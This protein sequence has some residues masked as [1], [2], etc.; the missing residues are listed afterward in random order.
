LRH[1]Y[2]A[3]RALVRAKISLL[4]ATAADDDDAHAYLEQCA[5]HLGHAVVHLLV[6]GGL[7]GTGK[8]TLAAAVSERTGWHLV[9]S[10][11][12]RKHLVGLD[13]SDHRPASFGQGIYR[14][15]VS[16]EVY[17]QMIRTAEHLLQRGESVILDASF[18]S[19]AA[20]RS[21]RSVAARTWSSITSFAVS[22]PGHWWRPGST[23]RMRRAVSRHR[24]QSPVRDPGTGVSS[25]TSQVGGC[26]G[27]AARVPRSMV[28][29]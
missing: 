18:A 3:Y 17:A 22:L 14:A 12:V 16:A 8:S 26:H 21:A 27:V 28:T 15:S 25:Q 19:E 10:D 11:V 7:P 5:R 1:H 6:I 23:P 24:R 9:R 20:F 13:P 4:R 29:N 2:I